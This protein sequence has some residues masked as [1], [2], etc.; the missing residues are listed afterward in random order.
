MELGELSAKYE[1]NGDPATIS[2]GAGD[3]GGKSYGVYQFAINA[4][5]PEAFIEY[6]CSY[7]DEALANYGKTL[8]QFEV[9]SDDFD[10]QWRAIGTADPEGFSKLQHDYVKGVYY[11]SAVELLSNIG[12]SMDGHSEALQQVLWSRSVQYSS[13]WMPELF[14]SAAVLAGT[15]LDAID[16]HNLIY[17][18]YEVN[19]T[20]SSWHQGSPDVQAGLIN[21]FNNE[22]EEALAMLCD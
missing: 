16:D 8:A 13:Y 14:Q 2:D 12:F 11:D 22:R 1:S 19:I 6:A 18:I 20:D 5:V 3:Y 17:N 10:E 15:T 7:P 21:R 4:G 9:G